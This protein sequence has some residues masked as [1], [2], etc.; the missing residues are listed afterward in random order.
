MSFL[1]Q[2]LKESSSSGTATRNNLGPTY[3]NQQRPDR[4]SL[5]DLA[6]AARRGLSIESDEGDV[7]DNR[8]GSMS[9]SRLV[10]SGL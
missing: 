3:S 10:L 9:S 1:E 4:T 2:F 7:E 6:N 5:S 8:A